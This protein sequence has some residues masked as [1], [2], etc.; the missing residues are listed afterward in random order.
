MISLAKQMSSG[1]AGCNSIGRKESMKGDRRGITV[2]D[3][4]SC[5]P[6]HTYPIGSHS[7]DRT[8]VIFTKWFLPR[9][10]VGFGQTRQKRTSASTAAL[11]QVIESNEAN[12]A[13]D[14]YFPQ[15]SLSRLLRL[16]D[17]FQF[18][19]RLS[20]VE[21]K[22]VTIPYFV[23]LLAFLGQHASDLRHF[24]SATSSVSS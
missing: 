19:S 4:D 6:M 20:I 11:L 16:T 23:I 3:S 9:H 5:L 8:F 1:M 2:S 7:N 22:E 13:F 24:H 10:E 15:K 12:L 17:T 18:P 14:V 21:H